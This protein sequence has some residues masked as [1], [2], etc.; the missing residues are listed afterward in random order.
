MSDSRLIARLLDDDRLQWWVD[1]TLRLGD[2]PGLAEA[3]RE[4]GGVEPILLLP[5]SVVTLHRVELDARERRYAR[6]TVPF[7]LEEHLLQDVDELHFALGTLR[8]GAV[9]VAVVDRAW[10]EQLLLR[11]SEAGLVVRICAPTQAV[12]SAAGLR[13]WS[14]GHCLVLRRD[15]SAVPQ[16]VDGDLLPLALQDLAEGTL[17]CDVE[18]GSDVAAL[19]SAAAAQGIELELV[20]YSLLERAARLEAPFLLNFRQGEFAPRIDWRRH[21]LRWRV[22]AAAALAAIVLHTG[23]AWAEYAQAR[24][25]DRELR[26]EQVAVFRELYPQGV[27][28]DAPYQLRVKLRELE[29]E[30]RGSGFLQT[31][32]PIGEVLAAQPEL[33]VNSVRYVGN[34]GQLVLDL[35]MPSNQA[36][37]RLRD[38]LQAAGV[39]VQLQSSSASGGV[40]RQRLR[41]P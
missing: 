15:D 29:G 19:R 17:Q 4:A 36:F 30:A 5:P 32:Y 12:L 13:A 10:F 14:D 21:W 25:L 37:D 7:R 27:V 41:I 40:V 28:S 11:C 31:F 16:V 39:D 18:P 9:T 2:L 24:R 6:R 35:T 26:A 1:G 20:E 23:A 22:A 33:S 34:S 3:C 38:Q 8:D